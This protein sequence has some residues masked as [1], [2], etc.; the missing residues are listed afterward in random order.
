MCQY[1]RKPEGANLP[2]RTAKKFGKP[3]NF[4]KKQPIDI[5]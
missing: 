4:S 5:M 3:L 2:E 1:S